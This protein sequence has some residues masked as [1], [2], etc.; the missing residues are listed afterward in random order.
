MNL[1]VR[2]RYCSDAVRRESERGSSAITFLF[3]FFYLHIHQLSSVFCPSVSLFFLFILNE[4]L[5]FS[6]FLPPL[7]WRV[8]T[9]CF[10]LLPV[11]KGYVLSVFHF[12]VDVLLDHLPVC[13]VY[14][15]IDLPVVGGG[16]CCL[17]CM[18]VFLKFYFF[19]KY[20]VKT[21]LMS[22]N[23]STQALNCQLLLCMLRHKEQKLAVN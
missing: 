4:Q 3:F 11:G 17:F 19:S 21:R 5:Y 10:G 18:P 15:H 13:G 2:Y 23:Q 9:L 22:S 20:Q 7:M 6:N 1:S 16:G 14:I 12:L 8:F